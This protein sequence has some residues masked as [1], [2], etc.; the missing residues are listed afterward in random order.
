[1]YLHLDQMLVCAKEEKWKEME[2]HI[3]KERVDTQQG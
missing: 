3:E 2:I 1:M